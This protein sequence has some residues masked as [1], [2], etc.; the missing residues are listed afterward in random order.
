MLYYLCISFLSSLTTYSYTSPTC[1]QR[2]HMLL[3]LCI[4][5]YPICPLLRICTKIAKGL[6]YIPFALSLGFVLKWPKGYAKTWGIASEGEKLIKLFCCCIF[7]CLLFF[8]LWIKPQIMGTNNAHLQAQICKPIPAPYFL[9][10]RFAQ[11]ELPIFDP[12]AF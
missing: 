11:C 7:T 5:I 12:S 1:S 2:S 3:Y 9:P 10:A 8:S 4:I 6:L